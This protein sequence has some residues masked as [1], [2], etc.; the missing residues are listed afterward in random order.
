MNIDDKLNNLKKFDETERSTFSY[1]FNHWK[2]YNL[3]AKKLKVWKIKYIFHD[4]YKPWL[5]L[6]M[7][8]EKLQKFHRVH[9]KH[10]IEWLENKFKHCSAC[11][12]KT[13]GYEYINSFDY[14]GALIDWECSRYTKNVAQLTGYEKFEEVFQM[15]NFKN[16]F[17]ELYRQGA[18]MYIQSKMLDTVEKLGLE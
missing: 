5:K 8:Y 18:F 15:E 17:S 4:W 10:H 9:S 13:H 1:W 3:V 7:P 11:L 12:Y 16:N 14:E 2:A 6:F